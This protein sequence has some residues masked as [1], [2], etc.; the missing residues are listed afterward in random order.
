[1]QFAETTMQGSK[2]STHQGLVV[3]D[4]SRSGRRLKQPI[5]LENPVNL[6]LG[7]KAVR[8]YVIESL[9]WK[10][11]AL[12]YLTF[13]NETL[14]KLATYLHRHSTGSNAT[15]YQYTYGV[16][17]FFKW[18]GTRPDDFVREHQKNK[19]IDDVIEK[20]ESFIGD[21]KAQGLAPGTIANH[22]KS[23][24]ALFR[25]NGVPLT[26]SFRVDRR[27]KYC[28]RAPTPKELEQ[29]IDIADLRER[30]SS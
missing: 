7:E 28:D 19:S 2:D 14:L 4:R 9:Y 6:S 24:R 5:V 10:M 17:R 26:L 13:Q 27:V 23:T 20:I 1:M 15:L 16:Y 8:E 30:K 21:M 11:P 18:L 3:K 12:I 25:V 29:I 22:V